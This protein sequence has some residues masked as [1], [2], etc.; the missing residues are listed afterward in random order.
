M[1]LEGW[2]E[3]QG[4]LAKR[5]STPLVPLAGPKQHTFKYQLPKLESYRKE[6]VTSSFWSKWTKVTLPE[7]TATSKSWI[8]PEKLR[9]V[10]I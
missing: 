8:D 1:A 2:R 6:D 9:A 3:Y 10:A 5:A 7:A 4:L